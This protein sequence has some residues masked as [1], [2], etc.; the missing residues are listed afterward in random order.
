MDSLVGNANTGEGPVNP[1]GNI[2]TAVD[3]FLVQ[4]DL[5]DWV[6]I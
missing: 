3:P 6:C 5:P 4:P 1:L 2:S